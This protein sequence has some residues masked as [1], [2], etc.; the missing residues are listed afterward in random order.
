MRTVVEIAPGRY[1]PVAELPRVP[2]LRPVVREPQPIGPCSRCGEAGFTQAGDA[3]DNGATLCETCGALW[4]ATVVG[5]YDYSLPVF[6]GSA[7][8][9]EQQRHAEALAAHEAEQTAATDAHAKAER[10]AEINARRNG[11]DARR[12]A[13]AA[14]QQKRVQAARKSATDRADEVARLVTQQPRSIG[15]I[16]DAL[17]VSVRTAARAVADAKRR[18]LVIVSGGKGATVRPAEGSQPS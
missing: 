10:A 11:A 4:L 12:R 7:D 6:I 16:A 17:G 14:A 5:F 9:D 13:N 15:E 8:A 2:V 18:E 3:A 1:V